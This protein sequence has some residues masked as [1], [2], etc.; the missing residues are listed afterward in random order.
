MGA[1]RAGLQAVLIDTLDR[2]PG[3]VDCPRIRRLADL[4]ELLVR[5]E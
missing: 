3:K 1:R 4:L 2:Y 5:E